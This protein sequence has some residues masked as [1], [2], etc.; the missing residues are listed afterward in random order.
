M[1]YVFGVYN[2]PYSDDTAE[3]TSIV[4]ATKKCWENGCIGDQDLFDEIEDLFRDKSEFNA[5]GQGS[6]YNYFIFLSDKEIKEVKKIM[7]NYPQFEYSKEFEKF[8][9]K[10]E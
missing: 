2:D 10:D 3:F 9:K 8:V 4:I 1:K 7:K 6:K 5:W